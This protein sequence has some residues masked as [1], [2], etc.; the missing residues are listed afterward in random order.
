MAAGLAALVTGPWTSLVMGPG[1][2]RL[3]EMEGDVK[4]LEKSE[5]TLEHEQLLRRWVRGNFVSTALYILSG[6]VGLWAAIWG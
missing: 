6:G 1:I 2:K 3:I 4:V 5:Q